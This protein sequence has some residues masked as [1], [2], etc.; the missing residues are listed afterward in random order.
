[1]TDDEMITHLR[2]DQTAYLRDRG[3]SYGYSVV[4]SQS[5]SAWATRGLE[6]FPGVRVYNPASNPGKKRQ[7]EQGDSL[8]FNNV[9]RSIQVAV[10]GQN[11]AS[12][13][14]VATINEIIAT[15]PDWS[16][17]VHMDVD[18]TSCAGEGIT[19]QVRAGVIGHQTPAPAPE[20]E[21]L[22]PLPIPNVT[23]GKKIT[24][25]VLETPARIIDTRTGKANKMKDG[26]TLTV[27]LPIELKDSSAAHVTV[28]AVSPDGT[29]Y[30]TLWSGNG[31]TPLAS[32]LNYGNGAI[33]NTTITAIDPAT[34]SF[35][36]FCSVGTHLVIDVVAA[37]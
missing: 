6:G 32:N 2:R 23:L 12:P 18:Y 25:Q 21:P 9:S 33:A 31:P 24:M 34:G 26:E 17:L 28:T 37:D 30:L 3:Y 14:A 5:G 7:A 35:A 1:M 8:N 22:P 4:V 29:G 16:V 15:R 11:A 10:G 20:P 36:V 19:A 13:A 27:A